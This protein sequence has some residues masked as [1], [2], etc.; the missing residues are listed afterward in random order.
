MRPLAVSLGLIVVLAGCGQ[1]GPS[2]PSSPAQDSAAT[3]V[4][5]P[6]VTVTAAP[7][8]PSETPSEQST[9]EGRGAD[10]GQLKL[11]Q[12]FKSP[13]VAITVLDYDGSVKVYDDTIQTVLIK[14]CVTKIPEGEAGVSFSW[15]PW[16][17]VDH[18]SGRYEPASSRVTDLGPA[19]PDDED[20]LKL[21]DCVKGLIQ[22]PDAK[23]AKIELVRYR[24]DA[25]ETAE[26]K[27]A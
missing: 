14:S 18:D 19:Y 24:N 8:T 20:Q 3:P 11:G 22:W 13:Y 12:T 9:V 23:D 4:P 25:G 26:W 1:A 10:G 21:G 15:S 2:T 16:E 27:V 17:L 6:T 5:G 7:P